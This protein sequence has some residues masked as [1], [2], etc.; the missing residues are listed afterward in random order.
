MIEIT[1][2][3]KSYHK[4]SY[5]LHDINLKFEKGDFVGVLGNNGAGKSTLFKI[6]TGIITDYEGSCLVFGEK[7]SIELSDR[8]SY[9]PE[10]RGLDS[11]AYVLEHLVDLLQYKGYSKKDA[12]ERIVHWMEKFDMMKYQY[13]R[14]E[15]LSKGNQQKLQIIL[16]IANKPEVLILD[17]PFS[18][19]DVVTCD[20]IWKI[21]ESLHKEAC[22]IIF[23]THEIDDKLLNCN[24]Y[25]FIREG[26]IVV[27]GSLQEIA[28]QYKKVLEIKNSS[29][30][31]SNMQ[32]IIHD[33]YFKKLDDGYY[34][35]I[36]DL[37]M[38]HKI[39]D[40]LEEKFSEKFWVREKNLSEIYFD[41]NR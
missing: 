21:L 2:V 18:G 34:I 16:A 23:S 29:F 1:N 17:E 19:L 39:F 28:Q 7:S 40:N 31:P 41:I 9:I 6:I 4:G 15:E 35:E 10:M 27:G 24:K 11:R 20:Y 33:N 36:D 26:R 32:D 37:E 13:N 14:V 25:L 30:N 12:K 38:A 8:I 22:T 5:A 3:S